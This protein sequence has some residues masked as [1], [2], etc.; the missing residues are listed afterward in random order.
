MNITPRIVVPDD[1]VF[2]LFRVWPDRGC[3]HQIVPTV[4]RVD[5]VNLALLAGCGQG[6]LADKCVALDDIRRRTH[7]IDLHKTLA[8]YRQFRVLTS[9]SVNLRP[10]R[11][12]VSLRPRRAR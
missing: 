10:H 3:D 7:G 12:D 4:F 6:D 11:H 9:H 5:P 2:V 8:E 1:V